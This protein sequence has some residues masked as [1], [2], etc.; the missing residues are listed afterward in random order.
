MRSIR[1]VYS[2]VCP[3]C[4]AATVAVPIRNTGYAEATAPCGA[5]LHVARDFGQFAFTGRA[6][7]VTHCPRNSA[8]T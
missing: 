4:G 3:A 8:N 7:L 6:Y 5:V 2:V 1:E